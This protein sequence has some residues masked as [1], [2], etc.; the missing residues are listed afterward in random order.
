[1]C[2]NVFLHSIYAVGATWY[3]RKPEEGIGSPRTGVV[4]VYKPLCGL[5]EPN[6]GP[7]EEQSVLLTTESS[8]WLS[9]TGF[10]I[11][12]LL[13]AVILYLPVRLL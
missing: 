2:A 10:S 3:P 4:D 13:T 12:Y 9:L 11:S 1:M 6:L 8:L 5:R 7:L